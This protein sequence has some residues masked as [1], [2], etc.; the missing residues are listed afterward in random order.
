M[1]VISWC[2]D[3]SICIF[4]FRSEKFEQEGPRRMKNEKIKK[5]WISQEPK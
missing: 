5:K 4:L 1:H 2:H 3:Y